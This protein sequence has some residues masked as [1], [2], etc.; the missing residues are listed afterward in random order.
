MEDIKKEA[1]IFV[2]SA[3]SGSGKTTAINHLLKK[4]KN[5]VRSVSITTRSPRK[6]EKR[7]VDYCFLK[8]DKFRDRIKKGYFL[9]WERVLGNYYGTPK[10]LVEDALKSGKDVILTIDVKGALKVKKAT[11]KKAVLIFLIQI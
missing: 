7:T 10:A 8:K 2:I 1:M 9:E 11:R 3:P 5:I 6:G 4:E